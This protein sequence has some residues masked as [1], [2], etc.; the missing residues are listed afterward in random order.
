MHKTVFRGFENVKICTAGKLITFFHLKE[1]AVGSY[2]LLVEAYGVHIPVQKNTCKR[3]FRRFKSG[4]FDVKDKER[5]GQPKKLE[6]ADLQALL[7]EDSTQTL[8][9]WAEALILAKSTIS[10]RPQASEKI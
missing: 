1:T 10:E 4:D 9:Q 2:S 7:D 6:R 8:K 5:P 3:W